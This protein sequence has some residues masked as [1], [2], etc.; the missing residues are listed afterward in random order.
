MVASSGSHDFIDIVSVTSC[1][2]HPHRLHFL[3][4]ISFLPLFTVRKL[5]FRDLGSSINSSCK[6]IMPRFL[7][8][9]MVPSWGYL[10][11]CHFL[12]PFPGDIKKIATPPWPLSISLGCFFYSHQ[13]GLL[14]LKLAHY[15]GLMRASC[16]SYLILAAQKSKS[17]ASRYYL[18]QD[19]SSPTCL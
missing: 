9:A 5:C 15:K 19:G 13:T 17:A 7:I 11:K 6:Y 12:S 14:M 16:L 8:D 10:V 3:H 2:S 18:T 4:K 1:A